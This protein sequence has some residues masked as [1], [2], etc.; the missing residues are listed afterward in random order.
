MRAQP[1]LSS[2]RDTER[3]EKHENGSG[4]RLHFRIDEIEVPTYQSES[5]ISL[6]RAG[7]NHQDKV[8]DYDPMKVMSDCSVHP[9]FVSL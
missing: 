1:Q 5:L 6:F 4:E 7:P 3:R 9:L 2:R 8:D